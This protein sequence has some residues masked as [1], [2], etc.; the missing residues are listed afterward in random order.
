[1]VSCDAFKRA[2]DGVPRNAL[3]IMP[4]LLTNFRSGPHFTLLRMLERAPIPLSQE[5]E[6]VIFDLQKR[7]IPALDQL[8]QAELQWGQITMLRH[9]GL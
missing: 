7:K 8:A 2:V 6:Q 3:L 4:P 5:A 9:K 1:V